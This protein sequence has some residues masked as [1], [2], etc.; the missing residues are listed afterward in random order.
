MTIQS[1]LIQQQG[2]AEEA[3]SSRKWMT[4]ASAP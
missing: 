1:A 2:A 4:N 3:Q